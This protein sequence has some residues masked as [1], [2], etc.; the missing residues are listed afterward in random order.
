MIKSLG[1]TE[2]FYRSLPF[3]I[4]ERKPCSRFGVQGSRFNVE[5]RTLNFEQA[6]HSTLYIAGKQIHVNFHA[7]CKLDTVEKYHD[8]LFAFKFF[9]K[10]TAQAF[11][12]TILN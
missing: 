4:A 11:K 9:L 12:R 3:L 2:Y 6:L 10:Y 7:G 8:A 5:H 1:V